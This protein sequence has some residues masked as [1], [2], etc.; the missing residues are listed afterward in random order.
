MVLDFIIV[1]DDPMARMLLTRYC[2]R[3]HTL[4]MR[5]AFDNALSALAFMEKN[6]LDLVFL[7]IEMPEYTGIDLLNLTP[8]LPMTIFTTSKTDYAYDAFQYNAIDFLKKPFSFARFLK[9]VKKAE[10]HIDKKVD[11]QQKVAEEIYV[12]D[13]GRLTKINLADVLYFES[14]ADYVHIKTKYNKFTILAALKSL[15]QKLPPTDFSKV[16][17]SYIVNLKAIVDIEDHSLVVGKKVIP[18]SRRNKKQLYR[19]LNII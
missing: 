8:S 10:A 17:R 12:K 5:G 9:A 13:N 4:Q 15:E 2:D 18:I 1:D 16:H 6:P 11:G 19:K 7:D 14:D 3:R